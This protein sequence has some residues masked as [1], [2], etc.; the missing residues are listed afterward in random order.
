M[1]LGARLYLGWTLQHLCLLLGTFAA[2]RVEMQLR[3]LFPNGLGQWAAWRGL[4][5]V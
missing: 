3:E 2:R 5:M 1:K 4:A